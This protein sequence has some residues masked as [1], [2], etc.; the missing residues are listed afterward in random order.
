M[1]SHIISTALLP[2][3][4]LISASTFAADANTTIT[5]MPWPMY[6]QNAAHTGFV[7]ATLYPKNFQFNWKVFVGETPSQG[8][9]YNVSG[10]VVDGKLVYVSRSNY[11]YSN[12]LQAFSTQDGHEVWS[13]SYGEVMINPPTVTQGKVYVQTVNNDSPDTALYAYNAQ[14]G[15]ILFKSPS[16]AQWEHYLSP[17]VFNNNVYVDGGSYGGMYSFD[18]TT[19]Q[20]NWFTGLGQFDKWTPAVDDKYAIAYT[21]GQLNVLDRLTGKILT[22]IAD[23]HYQW[24]GY[25]TDFAPVLID[26]TDVVGIQSGYITNFNPENNSI[27]WSNGPGYIGQPVSD[28]RYVYASQ[29]DGLAALDAKTGQ[30]IWRWFAD[31]ERVQGQMILTK[32]MILIS[33]DS[34]VY[35]ISTTQHK[36]VWS[37]A[38]SGQLALGMG[39]LYVVDHDGNLFSFSVS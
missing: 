17:T 7:N 35:A 27:N 3:L 29:N 21:N 2:C 32:N 37:Y 24:A 25:S 13:K 6:Q 38:T 36:P 23:P 4:I 9:V 26:D 30:L 12:T 11:A 33:T 19:G 18:S 16:R 39:H 31:N 20:Q 22:N 5:T 28:G 10:A 1:K 8:I 14:T 15:D 34:H